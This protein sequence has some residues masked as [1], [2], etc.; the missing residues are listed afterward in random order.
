[1]SDT[2]A[3]PTTSAAKP[4]PAADLLALIRE[5]FAVEKDPRDLYDLTVI[6]AA[7]QLRDLMVFLRDDARLQMTTLL[8]VAGVDYLSFPGHRAA[9]FAV[10]YLLKS[11]HFNHRLKVKV[12]VEEEDPRVPSL[13]DLFKIADWSERETWDQLGIVF[14]GHPN[15]KR[16]LNHHEFIG[17]PLRKDYPCQKRQKLSVNDPMIDQL[18]M[19]L[20]QLGYTILDE[21][22]VHQPAQ[23]AVTAAPHANPAVGDRGQLDPDLQSA[24]NGMK[25]DEKRGYL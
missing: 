1:M 22:D 11:L 23:S 15:L 17:H 6:V 2:A 14:I 13:H 8:D 18:E 10:V 25:P 3:A 7:A 9:R 19:R 16:L 5:R 4:M 12:W 20:R 21:G 24:A